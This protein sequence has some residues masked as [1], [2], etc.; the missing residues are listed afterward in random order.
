MQS[1]SPDRVNRRLAA[2]LYSRLM[3]AEAGTVRLLREH[4]VVADLPRMAGGSLRPR[5]PVRDVYR[6]PPL[7]DIGA[8]ASDPPHDPRGQYCRHL[9]P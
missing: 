3:E 1:V 5:L 6:R 2:I 8:F 4:R 7:V 9:P